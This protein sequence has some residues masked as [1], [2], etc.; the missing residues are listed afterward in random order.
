MAII[1][2]N[3]GSPTEA[4]QALSKEPVGS[5]QIGPHTL[6]LFMGLIGRIE[7]AGYGI[8]FDARQNEH[9]F[10]FGALTHYRGES[11]ASLGS[12]GELKV[13]QQVMFAMQNEKVILVKPYTEPPATSSAS[14][15][16]SSS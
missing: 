5:V 7:S 3:K 16:A 10:K 9:P 8:I 15:T 6:P 1:R 14:T 13:G 11:A 4:A 2:W 12:T